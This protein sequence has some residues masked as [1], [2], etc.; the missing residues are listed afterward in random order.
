MQCN[1][2]RLEDSFLSFREG[3]NGSGEDHTFFVFAPTLELKIYISQV[4]I[5]L[6]EVT[7]VFLNISFMHNFI[8]SSRL[9]F[10]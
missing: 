8:D 10:N 7:T 5:C 9:P 3:R 6:Q 4:K 2:L 1:V